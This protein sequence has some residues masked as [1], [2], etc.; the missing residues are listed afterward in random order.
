MQFLV[1]FVF[2]FIIYLCVG[3]NVYYKDIQ[4]VRYQIYYTIIYNLNKGFFLANQVMY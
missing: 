1:S 4:L 2:L 3:L